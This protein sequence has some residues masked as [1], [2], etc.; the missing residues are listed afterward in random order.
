MKKEW[1]DMTVIYYYVVQTYEGGAVMVNKNMYIQIQVSEV[2]NVAF[3]FMFAPEAACHNSW[4][5]SQVS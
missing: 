3:F 1:S 4:K 5:I 2:R